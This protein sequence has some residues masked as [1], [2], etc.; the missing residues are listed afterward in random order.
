MLQTRQK[1]C[2]IG[3]AVTILFVVIAA[4]L[5][6]T[7]FDPPLARDWIQSHATLGMIT[8]TLASIVM[9]STVTPKTAISISAGALYGTFLGTLLV[10]V[11]AGT[12]AWLNYWIGRHWIGR[13][14]LER[15]DP[16]KRP[17][18]DSSWKNAIGEMAADANV[19][20]HLLVRLSPIPTMVIG[21]SM[22]A[23]RAKP[24]PYLAAAMLAVIPQA[25]WV[26]SGSSAILLGTSRESGLAWIST[27]VSVGVAAM[28]SILI[29]REAM[30]RIRQ[31]S[32]VLTRSNATRSGQTRSGH[33]CSEPIQTASPPVPGRFHNHKSSILMN[34]PSAA[35][36]TP[37]RYDSAI[38][39]WLL[40]LLML[41]PVLAAVI[42]GYLILNGRPG[43]A[44][45]LFLI[46]AAT[47]FVQGIFVV[48]CRYTV[49]EDAVSVRCGIL[50]YQIPISEIQ[51]IEKSSSLKSAPAL[52]LRR[53]RIQTAKR[54]YLI[55][56]KDREG[57]ITTIK[58][59]AKL[60]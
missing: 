30:K 58:Q 4:T 21:Y 42:G 54:E 18:Y 7:D 55:S 26:H 57:F 56:P 8:F 1:N 2:L 34:E 16:S 45:L 31:R 29:P 35:L 28:I 5:I 9:I 12:A 46:G 36:K 49:L 51:G 11:I 17:H 39:L 60:D 20:G 32:T 13:H 25:V 44:S 10:A 52:S 33:T 22:G 15:R 50:C 38:D 27:L 24:K 6:V 53:V 37:I 48:P 40:M 3:I 59:M 23:M 43:D 41:S 14:V 47:L 19:G